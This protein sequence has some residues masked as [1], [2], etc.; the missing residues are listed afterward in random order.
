MGAGLILR[1]GFV[2]IARPGLPVSG[3]TGFYFWQANFAIHGRPFISPTDLLFFHRLT[4]GS[5]HP[6]LTTFIEA[7]ADFY[8]LTSFL[9]HQIIWCLL[10]TVTVGLI[11]TCGR[12]LAG[13]RAG[14]LAGMLAAV[15]P[16]FWINDGL[17]ES[18]TIAQLLVALLLFQA[19]RF[20]K[21]PSKSR[22]LVIGVVTGLVIMARSEDLLLCGFLMVPL[23]IGAHEQLPGVRR[24]PLLSPR[25]WNL[26]ARPSISPDLRSRLRNAWKSATTWGSDRDNAPAA[27]RLQG[28]KRVIFAT[29]GF[30]GAILVVLPWTIH[31]L[32][33]FQ[34]TEFI[35]T[36]LGRTLLGSNCY[37][38]YYGSQL[39]YWSY[40]CELT[41]PAPTG[42]QSVSDTFYRHEAITYALHHKSRWIPV[43]YAR[44]G[45]TFGF[46]DPVGN[47]QIDALLQRPYWASVWQLIMYYALLPSAIGGFMMLKRRH[48]AVFPLLAPVA[49]TFLTVAVTYGTTRFRATC[50]PT[51]VLLAA[52]GELGWSRRIAGSDR[53]RTGHPGGF[54]GI[55]LRLVQSLVGIPDP[56]DA[57]ESADPD[58]LDVDR[59]LNNQ[60][61]EPEIS[62]STASGLQTG[63]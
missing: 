21:Q 56:E 53:A 42:D 17:V 24:G 8:G 59:Q 10:G 62:V 63:V 26:S 28:K 23:F 37:D 1:L 11:G 14:L 31:N 48:I 16:G 58:A 40:G 36:Q 9:S 52:L 41:E 22:A 29:I 30:G 45:R 46:Y 34:K 15:Y 3:D 5:D 32:T 39:G 12:D 55:A 51:L 27:R 33:T 44:L 18:E 57:K 38:T 60:Q 2:L 13:D 19:Y 7:V 6:P 61:Y 54:G 49:G 43:I 25:A 50:E 35:S 4:P 47:L 20:W